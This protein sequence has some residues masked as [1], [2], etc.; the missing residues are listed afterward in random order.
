VAVLKAQD[1]VL[2]LLPGVKKSPRS[3][4]FSEATAGVGWMEP[5]N[6]R[7]CGVGDGADRSLTLGG[8]ERVRERDWL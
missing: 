2:W 4:G 6:G 7:G 8:S 1:V 5:L 3:Y